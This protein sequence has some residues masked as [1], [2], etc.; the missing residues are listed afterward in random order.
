[1]AKCTDIDKFLGTGN[2]RLHIPLASE[3][4]HVD[5]RRWSP[6][7][8]QALYK[9]TIKSIP[10]PANLGQC[11]G[12]LEVDGTW[13]GKNTLNALTFD[14][15]PQEDCL[16]NKEPSDEIGGGWRLEEMRIYRAEKRELAPQEPA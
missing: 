9:A 16:I 13:P 2:L 1:M 7:V 3:I 10:D 8:G 6:V 4:P 15:D 12:Q 5:I 11:L 14:Y